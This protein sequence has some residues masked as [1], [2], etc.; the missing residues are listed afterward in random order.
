[1]P[2][3]AECSIPVNYGERRN[4]EVNRL[5]LSLSPSNEKNKMIAEDRGFCS[6]L[7]RVVLHVICVATP[8]S[9]NILFQLGILLQRTALSASLFYFVLSSPVMYRRCVEQRIVLVQIMIARGTVF[10]ITKRNTL[11][12]AFFQ[13]RFLLAAQVSYI[14]LQRHKRLWFRGAPRSTESRGRKLARAN[15]LRGMPRD[16]NFSTVSTENNARYVNYTSELVREADANE[17]FF[18]ALRRICIFSRVTRLRQNPLQARTLYRRIRH[19]VGLAD[20]K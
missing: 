13:L 19:L 14:I 9:S 12:V 1:M 11:V 17:Q 20:S 6:A 4:C 18:R 3:D 15:V 16:R 5:F 7:H 8:S 2:V 10:S